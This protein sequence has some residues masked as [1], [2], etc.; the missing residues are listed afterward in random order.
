LDRPCLQSHRDPE[1][2]LF[3]EILHHPLYRFLGL[4][5]AGVKSLIEITL[6]VEQSDGDRWYLQIRNRAD[7]VAGQYA[8]AAAVSGQA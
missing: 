3:E 8:Q 5:A 1:W 2:L 7:S 6:P 4:P